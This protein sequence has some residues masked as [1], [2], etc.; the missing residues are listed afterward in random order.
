MSALEFAEENLFGPLGIADVDWPT[1]PDGVSVGYSELRMRPH[2]MAKI[3]FLYLNEGQWDGEQI[4]SSKWVA[5]SSRE[6]ISATLEDGYGYQW[7]IDDSGIYLALGY[8]G[9]FIYVVPEKSLVVVFTST[10]PDYDFYVPQILL[11]DFIIPAIISDQ[12][13][14]TNSDGTALLKSYQEALARP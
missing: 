14:P 2:D 11:I 10:L 5:A 3:G 7:W 4:V 12:P 1:D 8:K 13:L 6:H 9:Q